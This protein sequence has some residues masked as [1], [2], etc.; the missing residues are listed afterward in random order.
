[1]QQF[2]AAVGLA[3]PR[4]DQIFVQKLLDTKSLPFVF[5]ASK[6]SK[7]TFHNVLNIAKATKVSGNEQAPF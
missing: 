6:N 3:Y 1:M 2:F 5:T 7:K 4:Y